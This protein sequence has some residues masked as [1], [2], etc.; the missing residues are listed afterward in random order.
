MKYVRLPRLA[1][2]AV[3]L[4]VGGAGATFALKPAAAQQQPAGN[5]NANLSVAVIDVDRIGNESQLRKGLEE[6]I[7]A[8][9]AT[10]QNTINQRTQEGQQLSQQIQELTADAE[11]ARQLRQQIVLKGAEI[12]TLQEAG[13]QEIGLMVVDMD[14]QTVQA[15]NE[16]AAQV[17]RER[18]IDLVLRKSPPLPQSVQPQQAQG[19]QEAMARQTVVYAG[20][21]ADITT[22]VLLK[23]DEAFKAG[24]GSAPATGGAGGGGAG[25]A[26]AGGR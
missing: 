13:N 8:Y 14:L 17:A 18:G 6:K 21:S 1:L 25:T 11:K 15:I 20:P 3:L 24:G 5:N 2:L 7:K 19:V 4:L 22:A 9:K 23:M 16:A 26:P 10:I 12:K